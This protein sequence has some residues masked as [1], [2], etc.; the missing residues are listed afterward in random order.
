MDPIQPSSRPLASPQTLPPPEGTQGKNENRKRTTSTVLAQSHLP[1]KRGKHEERSQSADTTVFSIDNDVDRQRVL[2]H[3]RN[4]YPNAPVITLSSPQALDEHHLIRSVVFPEEGPEEGQVTVSDGLLFSDEPMTLV[5]DLTSMTPGQIASLNDLL[6]DPP[7]CEGRPLSPKVHRI[8]LIKSNM[9]MTG[10]GRP[11]PDC[12]RRLQAFSSWQSVA[13]I[14]ADTNKGSL[15]ERQSG[16][17]RHGEKNGEVLSNRALLQAKVVSCSSSGSEALSLTVQT[18]HV[19]FAAGDNWR[20]LLFGGLTLNDQGQVCFCPGKLAELSGDQSVI[21]H[22]APW[23]KGE[24]VDTLATALREGG[25]RANGQWVRLPDSVHFSRKETSSDELSALKQRLLSNSGTAPCPP[26]DTK[27]AF[28]CLNGDSLE[29]ALSNTQVDGGIPRSV[30]TLSELLGDC[31]QLRITEELT[32][33]QWLRLLRRVDR[34]RRKPEIV[35]EA[36]VKGGVLPNLSSCT[37]GVQCRTYTHESTALDE[38][39]DTHNVYR[40]TARDQWES[41]WYQTRMAS[42]NAF[43][44][45]QEETELLKALKDGTPVVLHGMDSHPALAARLESLLATP[46]YVFVSGHKICLPKAQVTFLWPE[47]LRPEQQEAC[48][49]LSLLWQRALQQATKS[50]APPPE[51]EQLITLLRAL[52]PSTRKTYPG[53]VPWEALDFQDVLIQQVEQERQQDGASQILPVHHRKAL[54]TLLVKSYRGDDEVYGYLKTQ[55]RRL[56]PDV[57]AEDRADRRALQQWLQDHPGVDRDLLQKHFWSLARHC[58]TNEWGQQL[59]NAYELPIAENINVLARFLVGCVAENRQAELGQQLNIDPFSSKSCCY[60]D[61]RVRTRLR[62][63]LLVAGDQRKGSAPVSEQLKTL[64]TTITHIIHQQSPEQAATRIYGTLKDVFSETLLAGDFKDL[65]ASLV[66]GQAGS[67]RRQQRRVKRLAARVSQHPLVFLQGVAGAGKSHMA[68]AVVGELRQRKGWETMPEPTVLSLGPETT[69]ESLYGQQTLNELIDDDRSTLFVPGPILEWAMNDNPPVL[70]LDEANLVREGVLA[71]LAGLT[72]KPPQLCFQ[73]KV[74]P[75]SDRHRVILTGNPDHYDGR[76]MDSA[77]KKRMLTLYYRPLSPDTLAELIIQPALPQ[78]WSPELKSHTTQAILS[79]Y[80]HYGNLLSDDLSP[81]DLQDVLAR[82]KQTLRHYGKDD[83]TNSQAST[84]V[85]QAF[86]DSLAGAIPSTHQPRATALEHWYQGHFPTNEPEDKHLI[87]PRQL[88]FQC[89]LNQLRQINSDIDLDTGPVVELVRHYWLFLDK[90]QGSASRGRIG[91]LVDG[92]A[93]WGKDLILSRVLGLWQQQQPSAPSSS[94]TSVHINANPAQWDAQVGLIK[95]AMEQG[96]KLVISELNLLPSGYL[97]ELFN[98]VLTG[99][100]QPGFALFAT[101]N[102]P[103]FGGREPLSTALKNRCSQIVLNPLDRDD[104]NGILQRRYPGQSVLNEWLSQRYRVLSDQLAKRHAPIQLTLNDL[105][106]GV[107]ALQSYEQKNW[108][109]RF[110]STY[111]LALQSLQ[112][113]PETLEETV[114]ATQSSEPMDDGRYKRQLEL[115][116]WINRQGNTP[117]TVQLLPVGERPAFNSSKNTLFLPDNSD[118]SELQTMAVYVLKAE[119]QTG[120][121]PVVPGAF[122]GIITQPV[123]YNIKKF[124]AGKQFDTDHYRLQV[125]KLAMIRGQLQ[126]VNVPCDEGAVEPLLLPH[127]PDRNITLSEGQQLGSGQFRLRKDKWL[128]LPGLSARDQLIHLRCR[129]NHF[130]LEVARGRETGQLL[131]KLAKEAPEDAHEAT[132]DF[133]IKPDQAGLKPLEPSDAIQVCDGLCDPA[134]RQRLDD[135]V[136]SPK[137]GIHD[138]CYELQTIRDKPG[139]CQQLL[140]LAQWCKRFGDTRD[141][142]GSGLNL[143]V[144]LIREKQGNCSHRSQ[145]FQVLSQYFG[146]PARMLSNDAHQYV[147]ISPDSGNHWRRVD[148][149]G[150]GQCTW[151]EQAS[152]FPPE[153]TTLESSRSQRVGEAIFSEELTERDELLKL[154]DACFQGPDTARAWQRFQDFLTTDFVEKYPIFYNLLIK[155]RFERLLNKGFELDQALPDLFLS[156]QQQVEEKR[157]DQRFDE[158]YLKLQILGLNFLLK[159][160]NLWESGALSEPRYRTMVGRCLGLIKQGIPPA[161]TVLPLLE[162]LAQDASRGEQAETMLNDFYQQLTQP[163][164]WTFSEESLTVEPSEI[165][166]LQGKSKTLLTAL[167]Q[168][169]VGNEWSRVS[170]GKPPSIERMAQKQAAFPVSQEGQKARPVFYSLPFT[171]T[172]TRVKTVQQLKDVFDAFVNDQTVQNKIPGMKELADLDNSDQF[173]I[174]LFYTRKQNITLRA[175]LTWLVRQDTQKTWRCLVNEKI[176]TPIKIIAPLPGCYPLIPQM[177]SAPELQATI[178][179]LSGCIGNSVTDGKN[180]A[181]NPERVKKAFGEP[182]ALVITPDLLC[183]AYREYLETMDW[184]SLLKDR[185]ND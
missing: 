120:S 170:S 1:A 148:L 85:W 84:L 180:P 45:E 46:P 185:N 35:D 33:Q 159:I 80:Q 106:R 47:H 2:A 63:A 119:H 54:H 18:V 82:M 123:H 158:W 116:L 34:L 110:Q 89:F 133:I 152:N 139:K 32:D 41:L 132:L 178:L 166:D 124:F 78:S 51:Q 172:Y 130:P 147:E 145:V 30:D 112:W 127:W 146:V 3:Y 181:L 9:L 150:G 182:S 69:P 169:S 115:S 117:V 28:V 25:Y 154:Y 61:D 57:P 155:G 36:N 160:H 23:G 121:D 27:P 73:G 157:N 168:T 102:P 95:T 184:S 101:M 29:P 66:T 100:A 91:L 114:M 65:P 16:Q 58:P 88:A 86:S 183:T 52:P 179:K 164:Q 40:L 96:Q 118:P 175:F 67:H 77:L 176:K 167:H 171:G 53:T 162:Q 128:P 11:G 10:P 17:E 107:E 108:Q 93:G 50:A 104:L 12:W 144:N 64:E 137:A 20:T 71:P 136:F 90:Q 7:E 163:R 44:F 113:S 165:I 156:W 99:D 4:Q 87:E 68:Q 140:A 103:S 31:Q 142:P 126:E 129:Q 59:P 39:N 122:G 134:I 8:V 98:E 153:I 70:I 49:S 97:E 109:Q 56:Y 74:Y 24:F 72:G 105:F 13:D 60:F 48:S 81:R 42:E 131:V 149:G 76:H 151:T 14:K 141:V 6:D 138:T 19:D 92:P 37:S 38:F 111:G 161:G 43:Q 79:L 62:D 177:K 15:S 22:D 143:L 125:K 94:A 75:L 135:D 26:H 173:H 83:I 55:I 174:R 21:L 5:L